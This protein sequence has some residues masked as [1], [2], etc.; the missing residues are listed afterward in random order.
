MHFVSRKNVM[1]IFFIKLANHILFLIFFVGNKIFDFF[2]KQ[3]S[4]AKYIWEM[5]NTVAPSWRFT[6]HNNIVKT[7]RSPL[8]ENC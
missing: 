5:L 6:M 2:K 4:L 8:K 1:K 3:S 7:L